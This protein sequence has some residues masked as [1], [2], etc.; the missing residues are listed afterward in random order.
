MAVYCLGEALPTLLAVEVG[1][2]WDKGADVV[3]V[4]EVDAA[5]IIGVN[6]VFVTSCAWGGTRIM[7][8]V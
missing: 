5:L 2:V 4:I 7:V 6:A 8:L 1:V 3:L